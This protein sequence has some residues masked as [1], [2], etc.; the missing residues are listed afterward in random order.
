[1]QKPL[2]LTTIS[3]A[4][5]KGEREIVSPELEAGQTV[6]VVVLRSTPVQRAVVAGWIFWPKGQGNGS[7]RPQRRLPSVLDGCPRTARGG[8][9]W[10]G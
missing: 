9:G 3:A 2:H 4:R 8:Q 1:M 7:S 6:D 10:G 5:W